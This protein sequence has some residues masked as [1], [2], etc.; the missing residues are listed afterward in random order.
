MGK[1]TSPRLPMGFLSCLAKERF[2]FRIK[3]I[4]ATYPNSKVQSFNLESFYIACTENS[5]VNVDLPVGCTVQVTSDRLNPTNPSICDIVGPE[6][7]TFDPPTITGSG[8]VTLETKANMTKH[9]FSS[10]FNDLKNVTFE[11]V[12]FLANPE[13][14][15][16]QWRD[17]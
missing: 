2:R 9:T 5:Q 1:L 12:N 6:N 16:E 3:T 11:I 13:L 8:G 15:M 17:I 14:A 4:T 7:V 10:T